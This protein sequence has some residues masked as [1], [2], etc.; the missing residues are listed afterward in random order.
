M[1]P[2]LSLARYRFTLRIREPVTLPRHKGNV[3]RGGFGNMFRRVVCA[4][5]ER[6]RCVGCLL[7]HHCAYGVLF[8]PSPPPGAEALSKNEAVPRPFVIEPPLGQQTDYGKD[9]YLDFGLILIG[10]ATAYLPYFVVAFQELGRR[11]LGRQS[12][13]FELEQVTVEHPGSEP[14]VVFAAGETRDTK[15]LVTATEVKAWAG[16]L[17]T[18]QIMLTLLTPTRLK[19]RGRWVKHGPPFGALIKTLLGR[20]SS[21]SYFHCG[22]RFETDFRGLIDR[23][24][25]V[26]VARCETRW[27]DWSRFSG[28]QKQRV[29]MGGL[30]GRV[31]YEGNLRDY[32]P[33]LALGEL[34]HVG[35]G[36]VFGNG[37]YRIER[38]GQQ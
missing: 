18:D 34:V 37:Q 36:T 6:K 26:R 7:Q 29:R 33:L 15:L 5:P 2:E 8:E 27:E 30:V 9:E 17:P 19:H 35:K 4:Q 38:D 32:L 12:G 3:L 11:G 1:L 13:R 25:E 21:L 28:R 23:A 22:Q 31:A 20:V 14:I 24:A 10:Q 16:T